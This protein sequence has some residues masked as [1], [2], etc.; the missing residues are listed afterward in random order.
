MNTNIGANRR[1]GRNAP[2]EVSV[3][4]LNTV[5]SLTGEYSSTKRKKIEHTRSS[6]CMCQRR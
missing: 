2:H 5:E 1:A 6:R 4:E 3:R